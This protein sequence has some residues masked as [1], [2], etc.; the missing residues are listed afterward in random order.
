MRALLAIALGIG[1]LAGGAAS[2]AHAQQTD[3][4]PARPTPADTTRQDSLQQAVPPDTVRVDSSAAGTPTSPSGPPSTR[5]P[6]GGSTSAPPTAAGP[7]NDG[8]GGANQAVQLAAKDSLII[9]FEEDGNDI[10]TL[11]G[12]AT[13]QYQNASLEGPRI[14]MYFQRNEL[15]ASEDTTGAGSGPRPVFQ[16]G[17]GEAFTGSTLSYNLSS[18]R[19]RVVGARRAMQDGFVEG[20]VSK[21]YEDSTLFVQDALYTTCNCPPGETPSYSLR[22]DEMKL[23]DRWVY[24]GPIQLFIFNIPTP[25]WLPFGFLPN[26]EGRRSGPLPPQYGQDE[27]GLYLKDWGWYFAMNDYMDL[28]LQFGLWSKG[29]YEIRP[30]FRYSTRYRYSGSLSLNYSYNRRGERGDPDFS[31]NRQGQLRWSHRQEINP[32]SDFNSNLNLVTSSNYLRSSSN[33]Y[34]DIVRQS[35]SSSVRYSKSW[36]DGGRRFNISMNHNQSF[37]DNSVNLTIPSFSFRQQSIKPFE[38]EGTTSRNSAWYERITFDSYN[39]NVD[40]RYDFRPENDS[41]ASQIPWY[42]ALLSPSKYRQATGNDEPFEFQA[43]H[44]TGLSVPFRLQRYRL[45]LSPNISYN[46]DWY[47]RTVRKGLEGGTDSTEA[48]VVE[49]TVPGFFARREFNTSVSANTTFYGIFPVG[50]GAYQ[51]VRHTVRPSLSFGYRPNYNSDFWG[52]TRTFENEEGEIERYDIVNGR[53]VRGNSE[54]RSMSFRVGNVFET[55]RVRTDSTG[56]TQSESIR[57]L[58]ADLSSSYNFAADS[59][60]LSDIQLSARTDILEQFDIS[61]RS[62]F[63]PYALGPNGRR[64]NKFVVAQ[65]GFGLA[66]LTN[67]SLTVNTSFESSNAQPGARPADSPR[68]QYNDPGLGGQM[69]PFQDG[70]QGSLPGA[71]SNTPTGY[72]D[73]AIPWSVDLDFTYGLSRTGTRTRR[74]ANLNTRINFN[75][76]EKWRVQTRSGYDFVRKE[77]VTTNVSV[78]R[79][80]GCWQMSFSWVPFGRAQSYSFDLHVK[81]G[82]LRDL[83]RLRLPRSDRGGRFSGIARQIGR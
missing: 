79:D 30:L 50:V 19:G 5:R 65:P 61:F 15:R 45:N 72:A 49:S 9:S 48:E 63:S 26:I 80:L 46:S 21:V 77:L 2:D 32:T 56:E 74:R 44:T 3:V 83:L 51:G 78:L 38:S 37:A 20:S 36:P 18:G 58:N 39:L 29:S 13:M 14:D 52:Y 57:L 7:P 66:R 71:Y 55:K 8:E 34:D 60:K 25:F 54:S 62:T 1:L 64:I 33:S 67:M 59:L 11:H 75:V 27:R 22:G 82:K 24:S 4:P 31:Q 16:Q 76:T 35:I 28:Q 47:I 68:A 40:N 81:S 42:E 53:T 69:T 17:E 23:S 43:T 10:G 6:P 70:G 41:L 73:F 12:E